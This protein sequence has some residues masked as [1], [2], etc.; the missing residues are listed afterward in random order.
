M[1]QHWQ[2]QIQSVS[3]LTQPAMCFLLSVRVGRL[4]KSFRWSPELSTLAGESD[5]LT[6]DWFALLIIATQ[7]RARRPVKPRP[8]A[9]VVGGEEGSERLETTRSPFDSLLLAA[10]G[11]TKPKQK[12]LQRSF[13]WLIIASSVEAR[14]TRRPRSCEVREW[15]WLG[16]EKRGERDVKISCC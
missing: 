5:P 11:E 6:A 14:R 13:L 12:T 2:R 4:S 3:V 7:V 16:G 1:L 9:G 15:D 8:L 10:Q